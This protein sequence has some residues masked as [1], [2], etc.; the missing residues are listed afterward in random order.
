MRRLLRLNAMLIEASV[1]V[2]EAVGGLAAGG[3]RR[4]ASIGEG[5]AQESETQEGQRAEPKPRA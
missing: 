2:V 1:M 3:L 5:S 4:L